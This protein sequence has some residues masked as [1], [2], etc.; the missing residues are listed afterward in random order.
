MKKSSIIVIIIAV[1]FVGYV[2]ISPLLSEQIKIV[3]S[4]LER[5]ENGR[6][7]VQ[8]V[9][10]NNTSSS[11][12]ADIEVTFFDKDHNRLDTAHLN[13]K[14]MPGGSEQTFKTEAKIILVESYLIKASTGFHNPYGN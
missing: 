5:G 2:F 11:I 1:I 14:D 13:L 10:S 8:G 4:S 9:I 7:Y 3:S 12:D 6:V